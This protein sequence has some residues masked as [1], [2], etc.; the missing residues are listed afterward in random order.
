MFA[1]NYLEPSVH[2][3]SEFNVRSLILSV[4]K[5][6]AGQH[7]RHQPFTAPTTMPVLPVREPGWGARGG[8]LLP[9]FTEISAISRRDGRV[10]QRAHGRW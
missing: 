6:L 8:A 4:R 3:R 10:T 2:A 1:I 7:Q 5:T 9:M